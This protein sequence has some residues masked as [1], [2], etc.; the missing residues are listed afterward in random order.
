MCGSA[1]SFSMYAPVLVA[2]ALTRERGDSLGHQ[3]GTR[4]G[5]NPDRRTGVL[6]RMLR[7]A[8][9]EAPPPM[10]GRGV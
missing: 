3:G 6:N 2:S 5:A 9:E 7:A 8:F 10:I 4:R 1:S